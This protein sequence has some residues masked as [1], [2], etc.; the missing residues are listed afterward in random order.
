[1]D[2]LQIDE[3]PLHAAEIT[4]LLALAEEHFDADRLMAPRF[5]NAL[6]VY[7]KILRA[8]PENS[9][10]LAGIAAIRSKLIEYAHAEA[11][12][13]NIASARRQLDKI[14]IIEAES[15]A[16]RSEPRNPATLG[17][18]PSPPTLGPAPQSPTIEPRI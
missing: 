18:N 12:K 10:A 9:A 15:Q 1:M 16:G 6:A 8:D 13:G 2:L 4:R 3:T 5:D 14:Q 17:D 11:A 7:R